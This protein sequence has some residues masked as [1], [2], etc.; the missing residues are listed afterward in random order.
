MPEDAPDI[1]KKDT[2]PEEGDDVWRR[3][4]FH[5]RNME[6]GNVTPEL[7][8]AHD[9]LDFIR[10][11][12]DKFKGI[13]I[14]GSTLKGYALSDS[15]IQDEQLDKE[16]S[17]LDIGLVGVEDDPSYYDTFLRLYEDFKK[18]RLSC[19]LPLFKLQV[20]ARTNICKLSDENCSRRASLGDNLA[21]LFFPGWGDLKS[22]RDYIK[23]YVGTLS[24]EEKECWFDK[25][26]A[27]INHHFS[28]IRGTLFKSK[29]FSRGFVKDGDYGDFSDI[30]YR[31]VE[32]RMHFLFDPDYKHWIEQQSPDSA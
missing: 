27:N 32:K 11:R 5:G 21:A 28:A 6:G 26:I 1:D 9:L 20:V 3:R 10:Q 14:M 19:G 23:Q 22:S 12:S 2:V 17:D 7:K 30:T 16:I 13:T 8:Y 31:L 25:K 24:E 18:Y 29:W 15:A 4:L